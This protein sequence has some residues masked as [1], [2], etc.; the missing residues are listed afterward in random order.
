[1]SKTKKTNDLYGGFV[2][3]EIDWDGLEDPSAALKRRT[4][5]Y[6][7][8]SIIEAFEKEYGKKCGVKLH[9]GDGYEAMESANLNPLKVGDIF[10]ATI[11][12]VGKSHTIVSRNSSKESLRLRQNLLGWADAEPGETIRVEVIGKDRNGEMIIDAVK[13]IQ[14]DWV[15]RVRSTLGNRFQ[16]YI[17]KVE[18]LRVQKG[19]FHGKVNIDSLFGKTGKPHYIN[20]F[21]PGSTITLNIEYDFDQWN[22]KDITAMITG[23]TDRNGE[24]G[25]ICSRKKYLMSLGGQSLVNI[26]DAGYG[27]GIP[28]DQ[29]TFD[30]HVTGIINSAKKHGVFVEVTDYNFTGL[31]E[32]DPQELVNYHIGDP[33]RVKIDKLDWDQTKEP[34]RRDRD[35]ILTEVN[36][37]PVFA[38]VK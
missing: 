18:D 1:M 2:P 30:G 37:R 33:M 36:L 8:L 13:P 27:Q 14:D 29:M 7:N 23:F 26:F 28:F 24:M 34:Y 16:S 15:S 35:G 11:E 17:V 19:G 3:P 12:S 22:G 31:L 10:D 21:V 5:E 4:R 9:A 25:L 6:R 32:R 38:E 20:A